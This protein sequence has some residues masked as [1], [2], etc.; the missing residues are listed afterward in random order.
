MR[1]DILA[2]VPDL[3]QSFFAHSIIKRAQERN[4]LEIKVHNLHDYSKKKFKQIDDYPFGG[5]DGMVMAIEPIL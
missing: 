4:L 5:G 2:A 1:I 3:L